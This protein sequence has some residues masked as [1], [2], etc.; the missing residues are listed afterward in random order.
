MFL[1]TCSDVLW[2]FYV[3]GF[4]TAMVQLLRRTLILQ[5]HE[6]QMTGAVNPA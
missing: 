1:Q 4:S 6:E 2:F 5:R 3:P